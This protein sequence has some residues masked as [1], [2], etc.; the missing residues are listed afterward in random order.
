[1]S[2]PMCYITI[3]RMRYDEGLDNDEIASYE[4]K[5][6][7]TPNKIMTNEENNS[8]QIDFIVTT[9]NGTR[10]ATTAASFAQVRL[11]F[12]GKHFGSGMEI[13]AI[14]RGRLL[15]HEEEAELKRE[16]DEWRNR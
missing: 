3:M 10:W 6:D 16:K 12:F 4:S 14:E 11:Q 8:A 5:H 15:T 9:T 13:A 7:I 1:M 2:H